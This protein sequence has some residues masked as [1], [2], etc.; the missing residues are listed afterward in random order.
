MYSIR[1]NI[2]KNIIID[3]DYL[4]FD[5]NISI[6]LNSSG[7]DISLTT[8]SKIKNLSNLKGIDTV[9]EFYSEFFKSLNL[10]SSSSKLSKIIGPNKSKEYLEYLKK[11]IED[12]SS[13]I[14]SYHLDIFP[15]RKKCYENLADL[16]FENELVEKPIYEHSGVTGRTSIKK[17]FNFLTLKKDKRKHLSLKEEGYT[18]LEVDFKSCEPF[19][20]LNSQGFKVEGDDVYLWLCNKYN[21]DVKER[22]AVKRG[23][24]S[25]IYGANE[26]TISRL[27]NIKEKKIKEIKEDLGLFDLQKRLQ[28]EFDENGFFLNYYGRPITSDNNLINYWIQSS[29]VDFCSLAFKEYSEKINVKPAYFVHDSMTFRIEKERIENI[30][31]NTHISESFSNISIPVEYS[32][33]V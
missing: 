15:I 19:F 13:I 24:L 21:I 29:T 17:G 14:N 31:S 26:N 16:Y 8:L 10:K 7:I 28:K 30:K 4:I 32:S 6:N 5:N 33:I 12:Y 9:S 3:R 2:I 20:Y 22:S 1:K 25:M 27:M 23:I 18:L 11:E